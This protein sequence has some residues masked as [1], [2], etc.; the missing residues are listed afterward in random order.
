M[1]LGIGLAA[2]LMAGVAAV[3]ARAADYHAPR[4]AFGQPDLQ[5]VWTNASLTGLE[6][7]ATAAAG[8]CAPA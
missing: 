7:P 1:K 3:A 6:R 2:V 8:A 5:G 4:T